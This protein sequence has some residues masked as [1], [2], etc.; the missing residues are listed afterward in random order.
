[1]LNKPSRPRNT[2]LIACVLLALFW[3]GLMSSNPVRLWTAKA[4]FGLENVWVE[5]WPS[6]SGRYAIK[7]LTPVLCDI[8]LLRPVRMKVNP[9]VSFLLDPRDLVSVTI[10]R[11]REWQPEV[12]DSLSPALSEG[13]VFLDVGA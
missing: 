8:G 10:L 1:M 5:H 6:Q 13:A 2:A 4:Y 7:R 9:G 3:M 12:W 11:T